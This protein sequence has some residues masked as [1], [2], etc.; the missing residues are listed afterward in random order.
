MISRRALLF[1]RVGVVK[2]TAQQG[3]P[4]RPVQPLIP[5]VS[6]GN[7]SS[8]GKRPSSSTP[9][10]KPLF[11]KKRK[12]AAPRV[13]TSAPPS[14]HSSKIMDLTEEPL[15]EGL[16][17]TNLEGLDNPTTKVV[18]VQ[19]ES[20]DSASKAKLGY[21]ANYQPLPSFGQFGDK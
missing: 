19:E 17:I 14:F 15:P 2:K 9:P 4:Q 13:S 6:V 20:S 12:K 1:K 3:S 7:I 16:L 21:S 10:K 8:L 5:A 18:S 11:A